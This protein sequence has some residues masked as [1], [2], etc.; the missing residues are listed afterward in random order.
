MEMNDTN[1]ED[2]LFTLVNLGMYVAFDTWEEEKLSKRSGYPKEVFLSIMDGSARLTV[3]EYEDIAKK[4]TPYDF[5]YIVDH[6]IE[7]SYAMFPDMF[8][9]ANY[10]ESLSFKDDLDYE[11]F[12]IYGTDLIGAIRSITG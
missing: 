12:D 8:Y 11:V 7:L 5:S 4:A 3:E 1:A 2:K 10:G 9:R 6:V